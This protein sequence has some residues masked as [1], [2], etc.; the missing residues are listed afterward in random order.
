MFEYGG[1]GMQMCEGVSCAVS[2]LVNDSRWDVSS[3]QGAR[4][5]QKQLSALE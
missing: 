2:K 4:N 5:L 3:Q 1:S